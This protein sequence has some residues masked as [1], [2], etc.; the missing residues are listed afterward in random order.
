M[1]LIKYIP[2]AQEGQKRV[3]DSLGL[4]LCMGGC[5]PLLDVGNWTQVLCKNIQFS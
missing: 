3:L 1:Y 5:E 4:V 2:G